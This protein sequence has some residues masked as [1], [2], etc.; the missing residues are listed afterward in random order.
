MRDVVRAGF[1]LDHV[2]RV[3]HD[4]LGLFDARAGG[5][6]Q[7]DAQQGRI[8]IGKDFG[9]H[10]R[11]HEQQ[12]R[13][14]GDPDRQS[15]AASGAAARRSDSAR[16]MTRSVRTGL[17]VPR[18]DAL[19][20]SARWRTPAPGCSTAGTTRSSRTPRPARAARTAG[21]PTPTMKNDGT[22]TARM[23]NMESRR[24]I[25]VRLQAST[26][27]RARDTPGSIWLW[28]FSISTVASSTSTPTASARPPSVMMLM[29][30]PVAQSRRSRRPAAR[31]EYSGSRSARCASRAGRSAPSGR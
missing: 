11:Q 4:A 9:S 3:Q 2:E 30:W 7:A 18:R 6:A 26:T 13:D 12:Q 25:A 16:R 22:K 27:A 14:G 19:P 21:A 10:A 28:M 1:A 17:R 5:S 15:P 24:A 20:A 8:G 23:Q 31:T 29:V